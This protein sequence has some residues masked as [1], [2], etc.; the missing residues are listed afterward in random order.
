MSG[1]SNRLGNIET[2]IAILH[3]RQSGAISAIEAVN[4]NLEK[5]T[6]LLNEINSHIQADKARRLM[7]KWIIA[8]AISIG[9]MWGSLPAMSQKEQPPYY[10][11]DRTHINKPQ[12]AE[13]KK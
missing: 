10:I 9:A 13:E 3:E 2:E 5:H 11:T 12:R 7:A 8:V 4:A 1:F 6:A